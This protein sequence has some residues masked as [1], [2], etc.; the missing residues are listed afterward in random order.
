MNGPGLIA[1]ALMTL[2]GFV[3]ITITDGVRAAAQSIAITAG[4][5]LGIVGILLV[6]EVI[7]A[8]IS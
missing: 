8:A 1:M 5:V 3:I 7:W 4:A 2:I 6:S